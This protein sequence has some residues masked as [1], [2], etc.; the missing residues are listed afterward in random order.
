VPRMPPQRRQQP[1]GVPFSGP[2][3]PALPNSSSAT[4]SE[5]SPMLPTSPSSPSPSANTSYFTNRPSPSPS[6]SKPMVGSQ[7]GYGSDRDRREPLMV[8]FSHQTI[9]TISYV[10]LISI[11][12]TF[13]YLIPSQLAKS[14]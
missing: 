14:R 12:N 8:S 11:L 4:K 10:M 3:M 1:A 6:P 13:C 7:S 2:P 5:N 9:C